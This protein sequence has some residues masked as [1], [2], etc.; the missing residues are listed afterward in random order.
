MSAPMLR[1]AS[2]QPGNASPGKWIYRLCNCTRR[3]QRHL[4]AC[5]TANPSP[6]AVTFR[7]P[8]SA[9]WGW[10]SQLPAF[11]QNNSLLECCIFLRRQR[12]TPAG[13]LIVSDLNGGWSANCLL[14]RV[15]FIFFFYFFIYFDSLFFWGDFWYGTPQYF[16]K[17]IIKITKTYSVTNYNFNPTNPEVK[18]RSNFF[19]KK[20]SRS[21]P[22]TYIHAQLR[23]SDD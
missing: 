12:K 20:L 5:V 14:G 9:V 17:E 7:Y 4:N 1:G 6:S 10:S 23:L 16:W 13:N 15:F 21:K 3:V 19:L 11:K 8:L 18:P 22:N 2:V